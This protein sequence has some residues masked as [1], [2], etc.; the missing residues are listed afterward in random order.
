MKIN[1]IQAQPVRSMQKN[2]APKQINSTASPSITSSRANVPYATISFGGAKNKKQTAHY[3]A[4]FSPYAKKG[5]VGAV[6]DDYNN[7]AK[8]N[9][10]IAKTSENEFQ[11]FRFLP[12]YNG[13]FEYD[14][15]TGDP[16][17]KVSI[18]KLED[19]TPIFIKIDDLKSQGSEENAIKNKKYTVLEQIGETKQ[20]QWGLEDVTIGLYRVKDKPTDFMVY[21]ESTASMP[22]PYANGAYY[23]TNSEIPQAKGFEGNPYAQNNKA[24][25][26]LLPEA[27]KLGINPETVICSDAQASFI[28]EY[29]AQKAKAGNEYYQGVKISDIYHNMC[30]G[31]TGD[32]SAQEMFASLATKEEIQAVLNDPEYFKAMKLGKTEEYFQQFI[33]PAVTASVFDPQAKIVSPNMIPLHYLENGQF[34]TTVRTVSEG[35]AESVANNPSVSPFL[36]K[37][38]SKLYSEGKVGGILNGLDAFNMR[39]DLPLPVPYYN[40]DFILN[41]KGEYEVVPDGGDA[42]KAVFKRFEIYAKDA[43]GNL[44]YENM[45]KIKMSN[46]RNFLSRFDGSVTDKRIIT[47]TSNKDFSLI[48]NI[49]KKYI[50]MLDQGKDIP[51]FVSW[52][53]GDTQKGYPI[54]IKAFE[55]FAQTPEGKDATMIMGGELLKGSPESAII[56]G[57]MEK[58]N[59]N[60][61]LKGR[62]VFVN[63]FAPNAPFSSAADAAVL[64]SKFAPCE[65]TDLEAGRYFA[66]PIVT[67]TQGMAQ[68][69]F[70]PRNPSEA[71]KANAYKTVHEFFMPDDQIDSIVKAFTTNDATLQADIKKEFNLVSDDVFKNFGTEYQKIYNEIV[72]DYNYRGILPEHFNNVVTKAVKETPEY[73]NLVIQLKEN[74]LADEIADAMKRK[75]AGIGTDVDK[76]IFENELKMDTSW[77]GNSMLHPGDNPISSAAM[78]KQ[79]MI[80]PEPGKVISTVYNFN[81]DIF[82][83]AKTGASGPVKNNTSGFMSKIKS[84][85]KDKRVL[86]AIAG[87]AAVGAVAFGVVQSNKKTK[88]KNEGVEEVK[89]APVEQTPPPPPPPAP[90]AVPV[91][92][93]SAASQPIQQTNTASPAAQATPAQASAIN[94][95]NNKFAA[96]FNKIA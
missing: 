8:W 74:I 44:S 53:R 37:T 17:G 77:L 64:P 2:S 23:S 29:M 78:Y 75:I 88:S 95:S 91:S 24:Y 84:G 50:Q 96:C 31:Y 51:L 56:T 86:A 43:D 28:P 69:N 6:A 58:V 30:L 87:V 15:E 62:I 61:L 40:R 45:R 90:S 52:G 81:N 18:R 27:Q 82:E 60:P 54:A 5:G 67:N 25:V 68:K 34:V 48:G 26:E 14:P 4:E 3:I 7:M 73:N 10:A 83:R 71:A 55:K 66:T 85:L 57:M 46:K 38:W 1:A 92:Q 13:K 16:K 39:H 21:S 47:G 35:Y 72:K 12:Y 11:N 89:S 80:D 79:L 63:G 9:A 59:N 70:D 49:D 65:L 22:E 93:A 94:L 19:G 76:L 41:S 42:S 36:Y 33:K 32:I 20:M